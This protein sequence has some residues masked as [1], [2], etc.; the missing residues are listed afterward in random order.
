M[1]EFRRDP[2]SGRWVIIGGQRAD[3]PNEF[4]EETTRCTQVSCPFC[5]GNE[6]ETPPAIAAYPANL[7]A[8]RVRVVPNMYPAVTT[9]TSSPPPQSDSL[10]SDC[11]VGFGQHEVIIESPRHVASLTELTAE[12]AR[13]VLM[14]YR[15]RIADLRRSGLFKFVQIFKNVGAAAGASIEHSHSQLIALAEVPDV[16]KHE[17]ASSREFFR[18]TGGSLL[19][20]LASEQAAQD[21]IVAASLGFVAFCPFA[22]R[23]PFEVWLLPRRQQSSFESMQDGEL[24]ELAGLLQDVIGRIESAVGC[25]AYNY[26][27]HTE[28]F[29][30][31]ES[32]H[33]HWHIEIF[34][35]LT[36][37]A[38][39]EWAT[40]VFINPLDPES[41]AAALRAAKPADLSGCS[42]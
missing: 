2:L 17:V 30:T 16:I 8:W 25:V 32:D 13:L 33:Y 35:R 19:E 31:L 1:S 37:A 20:A 3:R 22:S 21:R 14:A 39:F 38:G 28:P 9:E 15:A 18:E 27:L 40:G 12:E 6:A 7:T 4:H 26:F 24:G 5:A 29:D 10:L 11:R 34:P 36:K 41:A 42:G 23:F